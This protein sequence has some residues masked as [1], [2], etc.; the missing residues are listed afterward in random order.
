M[1][2]CSGSV[3]TAGEDSSSEQS[4]SSVAGAGTAVDDGATELGEIIGILENEDDGVSNDV[5]SG[6]ASDGY[7]GVSEDDIG[8]DVET[9]VP[10][11]NEGLIE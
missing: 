10:V 1:G 9:G 8:V 3:N 11:Q 6:S 4:S 7:P 2:V 5:C